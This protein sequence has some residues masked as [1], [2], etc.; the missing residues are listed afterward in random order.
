[1]KRTKILLAVLTVAAMS[2]TAC[3]DKA[4]EYTASS[5]EIVVP[6]KT[7]IPDA[8]TAVEKIMNNEDVIEMADDEGE[9]KEV[10]ASD[11]NDTDAHVE[12]EDETADNKETSL[13]EQEI[14]EEVKTEENIATE[15]KL[16]ESNVE[17]TV[18][19]VQG[20]FDNFKT[21]KVS[22]D[23]LTPENVIAELAK[24]NI[25]PVDTKVNSFESVV[26]DMGT[27]TLLLDISN[28]YE[29]YIS[30]MSIEAELAIIN[31]LANT[32]IRAYGAD[33]LRLTVGGGSVKSVNL[34]YDCNFNASDDPQ[35]IIM[36]DE[37]ELR[38]LF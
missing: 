1:M 36:S 8:A 6:E 7:A 33:E 19:Y 37:A 14:T 18:Y 21:D 34:D 10:A 9:V 38:P 5:E 28:S 29:T 15:E 30:T 22:I 31:S 35:V 20:D 2:L 11:E 12:A 24:K 32:F 4:V 26:S 3:A 23:T 13:D 25:L 17:I 27:N 16:A